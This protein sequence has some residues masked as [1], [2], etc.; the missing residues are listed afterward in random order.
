[1]IA[2]G[3]NHRGTVLLIK[4][5]ERPQNRRTDISLSASNI[6]ATNFHPAEPDR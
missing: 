1:M 2:I 6:Y 4:A 3:T 5:A